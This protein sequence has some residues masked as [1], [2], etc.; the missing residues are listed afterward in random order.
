VSESE[1]FRER[2]RKL[3]RLAGETINQKHREAL[4]RL[5]ADW[6]LLAE[7]AARI[8]TVEPPP[9]PAEDVGPSAENELGP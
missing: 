1:Y 8:E 3:R 7:K 2:A 4:L 6:W 9:Q 5:A